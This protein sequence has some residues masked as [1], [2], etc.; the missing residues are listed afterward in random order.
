MLNLPIVS[1]T[2]ESLKVSVPSR[3]VLSRYCLDHDIFEQL[4]M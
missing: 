3:R 4:D 2:R 1:E